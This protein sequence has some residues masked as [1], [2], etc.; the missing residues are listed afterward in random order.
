MIA[1]RDR[2]NLCLSIDHRIVDGYMAGRF[3]ESVKGRLESYQ[4]EDVI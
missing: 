2:M 4:K 3:L 1:I